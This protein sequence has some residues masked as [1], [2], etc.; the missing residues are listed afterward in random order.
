MDLN[1]SYGPGLKIK[2]WRGG[3]GLGVYH[4]GAL[5]K[6]VLIVFRSGW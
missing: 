4:I 1:F 5:I 3:P 6:R 2:I